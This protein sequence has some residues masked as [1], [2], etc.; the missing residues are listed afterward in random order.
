VVTTTSLPRAQ[1]IQQALTIYV[2]F[3]AFKIALQHAGFG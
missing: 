2:E 1:K 3:A